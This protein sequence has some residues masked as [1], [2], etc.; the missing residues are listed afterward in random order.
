MQPSKSMKRKNTIP[1][2][3]LALIQELVKIR[4]QSSK[5]VNTTLFHM[6]K[7]TASAVNS[8]MLH[9]YMSIRIHRKW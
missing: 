4:R 1:I 7:F 8:S 9:I 2:V 6:L 3:S 5:N